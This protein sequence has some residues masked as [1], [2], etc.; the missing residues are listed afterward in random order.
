T[1]SHSPSR[2]P[3]SAIRWRSRSLTRIT[4]KP[5][6]GISVWAPQP[7]VIFW[8]C[9]T[10]NAK[11]SE[12]ALSVLGRRSRRNA[13][14]MSQSHHGTGNDDLRPEYDFSNGVRGKHHQAYQSGTNV[15]FL[16]SDVAQV[17]TDSASV[18]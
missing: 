13:G 14:N 5:N 16:D 2:V 1:V 4:R 8:S 11:D 12:P 18:N 7:L 10:L 17:F 6:G 9:R 3:A 15:I